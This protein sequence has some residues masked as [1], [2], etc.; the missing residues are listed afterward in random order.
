MAQNDKKLSHSISQE[1][2]IIWLWFLVLMCKMM[3]SPYKFFIS[4]NFWFSGLLVGKKDKKWP[5]MTIQSHYVFQEPYF[6]GL[7][8][9][10]PHM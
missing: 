9:F 2:Y 10:D 3:I 1:V 7:W 4:S 6:I 5:K 8:F